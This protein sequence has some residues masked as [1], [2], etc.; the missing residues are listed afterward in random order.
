MAFGDVRHDI[1]ATAAAVVIS[2]RGQFV[3]H[4]GV[5]QYQTV[6]FGIEG[7]VLE[8]ARTAVETH[9]MA[10]L[11][12][13]RSELIHDTAVHAY[14]L[15]LGGLAHAGQLELLN[16]VLAEQLVDGESEATL[17]RGR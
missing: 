6:A 12:E 2:R 16:L 14:V 17:Q 15:M 3:L 1:L 8:L 13:D 5:E 10:C 4:A 7:E 11:T 9:E